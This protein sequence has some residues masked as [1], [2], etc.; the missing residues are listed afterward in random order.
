MAGAKILV[1]EDEF[2]IRL[3]LCEALAD[4]GFEAIEAGDGQE[5]VEAMN[6]HPD[7]ALLLTDMQLPGSI[8]GVEVARRARETTPA[9]PVIFVTGGPN[10]PSGPA[11][12]HEAFITKPYL[13]SDV[14]A[15]VRRM[16]GG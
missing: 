5:A 7:V 10:A 9:I 6:S 12:P 2:L 1:V 4:E 16:I 3:M 11:S 13:P 15:T 14:C 8:T